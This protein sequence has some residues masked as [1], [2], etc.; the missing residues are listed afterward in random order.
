MKK[1]TRRH[2]A[3]VALLAWVGLGADGLSSACYGPQQAFYA[4]GPHTHLAPFLALATAITVFLISLAYNQVIRLFPNGGGGYKVASVLIR[5]SAGLISGAALIIDYILTIVISLAAGADAIFS[6][7]PLEYQSYKLPVE[8]C[9]LVFLTMLNL[10]GAKE[11]IKIL[12][13]IF[14]GF[15]ITHFLIIT[16]GIVLHFN[17]LPTV[18]SSD[19]Q[20]TLNHTKTF[21]WLFVVSLF[22]RAY[23][24]GGGT[25]TGLEAVS[26]N[27]HIFAEPRVKTGTVTMLYMA[28]SLSFVAGGIIFLY[29]LWNAAPVPGQTLNAV[30]FRE[31]LSNW[32]SFTHTGLTILLFFEAGLLVVAA[33]T[34]FLGAPAVLANM[35][36]DSWVPRQLGTLSNRLVSQN[37]IVFCSLSAFIVLITTEGSVE[38]LVVLY[39]MNVFLTFSTSLLGLVIYWYRE[40][41]QQK[42]WLFK[43]ALSGITLVVCLSI[44][45][46]TLWSKFS[47]GGWITVVVTTSTILACVIIKRHYNRFYQLKKKINQTLK[48]PLSHPA[49]PPASLDPEKT[50]AVFLVKEIGATLHTMLWVMRMF[51]NYF[52]NFV[53]I[54]AGE[55]DIGSFGSDA[56]LQKLKSQTDSTLDYLVQYAQMLGFGAESFS[57]FGTS[58]VD[59]IIKLIE[60]VSQKFENTLYFASRYVYPEE[61]WFTRMLHSNITNLIERHL[62]SL[63]LKLLVLPLKLKN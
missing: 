28:I 18:L 19:V 55:V 47:L 9:L 10:R 14:L 46:I 52:H 16:L 35:A 6:V 61:N 31:V 20:T 54:S 50:T 21:G 12:A 62:H 7:F 41:Q 36:I 58:A 3:L 4:L 17:R 30:A 48:I 1:E 11:S 63:G 44:L 32:P 57:S 34:G 51:P 49:A 40:R 8:C 22:M 27:V 26:N 45:I 24:L 59:E 2:I 38:F 56:A 5:P 25:Y 33:N 29:L 42:Y 37:G 39:S 53:F 13:F 23:S 15:F 43:T 60:T